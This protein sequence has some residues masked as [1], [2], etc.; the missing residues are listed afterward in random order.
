[1]HQVDSLPK[2]SFHGSSQDLNLNLPPETETGGTKGPEIIDVNALPE[3]DLEFI[4]HWSTS[5]NTEV[6]K[7][8]V[9]E[10]KP[11]DDQVQHDQ[12]D[13]PKEDEFLSLFGSK[14]PQTAGGSSVL[15]P[16]IDLMEE[17]STV[18][19][20]A[21]NSAGVAS[22]GNRANNDVE[23]TLLKELELMG[24]KHVDLNKEILRMNDFNLE[25]SVDDLCGVSE[26]D[27]ILEELEEMVNSS[28][29][30]L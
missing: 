25:Q 13:G 1:M 29:I 15:Y 3:M 2:E 17:T 8:A 5:S 4:Q 27:P 10:Q 24:F 14:P 20:S 9:T 18:K 28:Q 21:A 26:W 30:A 11:N 22:E 7:D 19:P 23:E 6:Q 16:I 12:T